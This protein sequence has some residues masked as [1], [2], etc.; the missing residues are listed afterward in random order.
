MSEHK[1]RRVGGGSYVKCQA[2]S[3]H[4]C[5]A[6]HCAIQRESSNDCEEVQACAAR[7][8]IISDYKRQFGSLEGMCV[9]MGTFFPQILIKEELNQEMYSMYDLHHLSR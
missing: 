4:S 9:S 7:C 2:I 6:L 3:I 1:I 5:N 8:Q